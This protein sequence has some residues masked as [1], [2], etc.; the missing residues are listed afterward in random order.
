MKACGAACHAR[1]SLTLPQVL[2]VEQIIEALAA[3]KDAI[4]AA[5][6]EGQ[7]TG[8]AMKQLKADGAIVNGKDVALAVKQLRA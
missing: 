2:S 5:D 6:S 4:L 3:V 1:G 7:A 8:V